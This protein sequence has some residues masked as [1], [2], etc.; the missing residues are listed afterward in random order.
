MIVF[1]DMTR[2]DVPT[3]YA[4]ALRAF[5]PDYEKYGSFPPLLNTG[6]KCFRPPLAWG[7]AVLYNDKV[8]GGVFVMAKA[9]KGQIGAIFIDPDHQKQGYGRQMMTAIEKL[10]P[11]VKN[12]T[13]DT[14]SENFHLHR[15]YESLGYVKTGKMKP[16][17]DDITCFLYEKTMPP[18]HT[19][20]RPDCG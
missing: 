16:S 19:A 12:W 13:L 3:L 7:K 18:A 17:P 11:K 9:E 20:C 8:I 2:Q 4:M 14:P 15:F 6:K 10:Y 1:K 5:Q